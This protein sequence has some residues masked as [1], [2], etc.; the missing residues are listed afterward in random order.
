MNFKIRNNKKKQIITLTVFLR[1]A[2]PS[3]SAQNT[4]GFLSPYSLEYFIRMDMDVAI[5]VNNTEEPIYLFI[6]AD[7]HVS[8]DFISSGMISRKGNWLHSQHLLKP[9]EEITY[10]VSAF[11]DSW[12]AA[13]EDQRCL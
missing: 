6:R 1:A 2:L 8:K 4:V 11:E 10:V 13:T 5:W 12:F 9:G 7:D 3:L